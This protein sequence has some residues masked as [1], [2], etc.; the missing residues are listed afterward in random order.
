MKIPDAGVRT[1]APLGTWTDWLF[2]EE[3]VNAMEDGYKFKVING[4]TFDQSNIFSEYITELYEL[5][6]NSTK[7]DPMY[8]IA[9]LLLNS[10]YGRFGMTNEFDSNLVID[11]MLIDQYAEDY[12]I[13]DIISFSNGKSLITF[14]DEANF[15][16]SQL[17]GLNNYQNTNISIG[18]AAAI[19]A[20]ARIHM[21]Q[22]KNKTDYTLYYSD[23]DSIIIDKQLPNDKVGKDIGLMK[24]ENK[25]TEGVFIAPKV[26]AG[27]ISDSLTEFT[28]V[29]GFKN[30]IDY[31]DLKSLLDINNNSLEL[32]QDKWFRSFEQGSITIKNQIYTLRAT[33]NKRKLVYGENKII[34]TTPFTINNDKKII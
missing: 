23:T 16:L 24:L 12:T 10:L 27:I 17:G 2:T 7:D 13:S 18:I 33:E 3:I 4:Y 9:K 20:Y 32:N 11:D 28:K 31:N 26:Y 1:V 34:G 30:N 22:F 6:V 29:K 14:T 25:L 5:K 21:S 15:E 19:A 8:L